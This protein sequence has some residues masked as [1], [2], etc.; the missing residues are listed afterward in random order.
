MLQNQICQTFIT[1]CS[2]WPRLDYS[3][4]PSLNLPSTTTKP[5]PAQ[6]RSPRAPP[7][8]TIAAGY[9]HK[10]K[11]IHFLVKPICKAISL[12]IPPPSQNFTLKPH[13][14]FQNPKMTLL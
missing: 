4:S 13:A 14:K 9:E 10:H 11:Q 12:Y 2:T 3:Q 8:Q 7:T 1:F 6:C 5:P